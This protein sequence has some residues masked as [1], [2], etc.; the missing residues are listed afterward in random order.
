[1]ILEPDTALASTFYKAVRW[2]GAGAYGEPE[3]EFV[4]FAGNKIINNIGK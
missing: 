4:D 3:P 2:F 1:M